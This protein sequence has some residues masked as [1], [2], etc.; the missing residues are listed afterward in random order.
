M[1]G[2]L[3]C[4]NSLSTFFASINWTKLW[5][6]WTALK[7][8][9][10]VFSLQ[11]HFNCM[12]FVCHKPLGVWMKSEFPEL[13]SFIY[14]LIPKMESTISQRVWSLRW[15]QEVPQRARGSWSIHNP[16]L[17]YTE[18]IRSEFLLGP[19]CVY[20]WF[21][22]AFM[23]ASQFNPLPQDFQ[24]DPSIG[25]FTEYLTCRVPSF[26]PGTLLATIK[27]IRMLSRV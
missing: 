13:Q 2:I 27:L 3:W 26:L 21:R 8:S 15:K 19:R 17:L 14:V 10:H 1:H 18:E 25:T 22:S 24:L 7:L 6:L 23:T 5:T 9:L 4:W 11:E 12:C 20:L 16:T